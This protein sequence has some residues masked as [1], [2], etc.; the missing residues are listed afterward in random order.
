M[1]QLLNRCVSVAPSAP[2][3]AGPCWGSGQAEADGREITSRALPVLRRSDT[4]LPT[5]P[6]QQHPA[7][8][9][10]ARPM[11][12][13][14]WRWWRESPLA[15]DHKYSCMK[16]EFHLQAVRNVDYQN[17][18]SNL[19]VFLGCTNFMLFSQNCGFLFWSVIAAICFFAFGLTIGL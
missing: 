4:S 2:V 12:T 18:Q 13:T 7:Q 5:Q 6:S 8:S 10:T 17:F 14:T 11:K 3:R 1:H 15:L 16:I 9:S 19:S